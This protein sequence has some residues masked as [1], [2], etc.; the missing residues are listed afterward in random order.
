MRKGCRGIGT[1]RKGGFAIHEAFMFFS[2]DFRDTSEGSKK[3]EGL[4][5]KGKISLGKKKLFYIPLL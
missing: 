3:E 1:S 2:L 5:P 4:R